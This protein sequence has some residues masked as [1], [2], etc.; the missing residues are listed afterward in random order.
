MHR[1]LI[2]LFNRSRAFFSSSLFRL[3]V[4]CLVFTVAS[5]KTGD[6]VAPDT[7]TSDTIIGWGDSL[8]QGVGGTP[9]LTILEQM[10]GYKTINEGVAG[11]TSQ[12]IAKRMLAATDKHSYNT[13][14]WA[15]RNNYYELENVKANIAAMVAALGHKRYLVIGIVNNI[16]PNEQVFGQGHER[17]TQLNNELNRI[18]GDHFVNIHTYLLAQYD[19]NSARDIIDHTDDV[20]PTSLRSDE[21]HLNTSGYTKVAQRINQSLKILTNR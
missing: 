20:V 21:L 11:Q 7:S 9:Y 3:T 2:R 10:T 15:G 19:R 18:Y 8:T 14:I 13:I 12:Q 16:A 1:I 4:V 17:I 6:A 5:C